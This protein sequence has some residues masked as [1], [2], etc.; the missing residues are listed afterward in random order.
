MKIRSIVAGVL[1][2]VVS[3]VVA[4]GCGG[5]GAIR[6]V[7]APEGV[8]FIVSPSDAEVLVDNVVRGKASDF[9]DDHPLK[10]STGGH[11]LE[12][13]APDHLSY[14]RRIDVSMHAKRIEATL[15]RKE[16]PAPTTE[17]NGNGGLK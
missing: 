16:A 2:A 13:R 17:R 12:L 4:P 11:M 9:T 15:L 8:S 6:R 1:L 5:G 3:G 14:I 7:E 10:V